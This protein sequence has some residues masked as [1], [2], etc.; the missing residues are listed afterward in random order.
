MATFTVQCYRTHHSSCN[1]NNPIISPMPEENSQS[2]PAK[3]SK[4]LLCKYLYSRTQ[5]HHPSNA[6]T[7]E[8]L[9]ISQKERLKSVLG[10]RP[11]VSNES[12]AR[13]LTTLLVKSPQPL[14]F[15][16]P[17][18]GA[19]RPWRWR[20]K[21]GV[22]E[23]LRRDASNSLLSTRYTWGGEDERAQLRDP[24]EDGFWRLISGTTDGRGVR[25]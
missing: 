5:P 23:S 7:Q 21:A 11:K 13:F 19:R 9:V 10:P 12:A 3:C 24:S 18:V 20:G 16:L 8:S 6:P 17:T 4:S 1:P 22:T 25:C 15:G 2:F 14:T